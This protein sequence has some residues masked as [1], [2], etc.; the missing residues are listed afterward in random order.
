MLVHISVEEIPY[1]VFQELQ[2]YEFSAYEK[3]FCSIS[4]E[5]HRNLGIIEDGFTYKSN[6]FLYR[7]TGDYGFEVIIHRNYL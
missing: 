4:R 1:I 7:I 3:Y 2:N 5:L 6:Q